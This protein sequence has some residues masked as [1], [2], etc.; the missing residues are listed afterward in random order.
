MGGGG[1]KGCIRITHYSPPSPETVINMVD[2]SPGFAE[3]R[4]E[5]ESPL[6]DLGPGP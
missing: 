4:L 3:D 1:E 2:E 6:C 5:F